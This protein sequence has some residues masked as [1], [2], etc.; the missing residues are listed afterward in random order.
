MAWFEIGYQQGKNLKGKK[1]E[2]VAKADSTKKGEN[3]LLSALKSD[4][5]KKDTSLAG[6]DSCKVKP[7]RKKRLDTNPS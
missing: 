4:T 5:V 6:T 3:A 7:H 2:K 1:G